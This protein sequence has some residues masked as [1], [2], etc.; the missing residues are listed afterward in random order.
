MKCRSRL[1]T[2]EKYVGWIEMNKHRYQE[3]RRKGHSLIDQM[4][5]SFPLGIIQRSWWRSN[6]TS[7][8]ETLVQCYV[9][10]VICW[11]PIGSFLF[12]F[13][14]I[15]VQFT[16]LGYCGSNP[17][18]K[19]R[20]TT[21]MTKRFLRFN[22]HSWLSAGIRRHTDIVVSSGLSAVSVSVTSLPSLDLH[23]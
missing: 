4:K 13:F 14:R 16:S 8:L 5:E 11:S 1:K 20:K 3:N 12:L 19:R 17:K 6:C 21:T 23:A 7:S 15:L 2:R 22:C 18:K 10:V 9:Y